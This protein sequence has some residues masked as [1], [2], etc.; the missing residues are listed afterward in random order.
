ML[1]LDHL[2]RVVVMRAIDD[3]LDITILAAVGFFEFLVREPQ[4][5][6]TRR[7]RLG[8]HSGAATTLV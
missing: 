3:V 1:E 8:K 4:R 2:S 5:L 7:P 6:R